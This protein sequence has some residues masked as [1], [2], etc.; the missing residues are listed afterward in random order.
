MDITKATEA[1]L[2]SLKDDIITDIN[3]LKNK[4]NKKKIT[5]ALKALAKTTF[6]A[7][8]VTAAL[9]FPPA[10]V[11]A[12]LGI[13]VALVDGGQSTVQNIRGIKKS[14]VEKK[15]KQEELKGVSEQLILGS[16]R[17]KRFGITQ[18][19]LRCIQILKL[20]K[21]KSESKFCNL[22]K[23]YKNMT[24]EIKNRTVYMLCR[25]DKPEDGT[26]IYVGST[27]QSLP[28]RL[29]EHK[30]KAGNQSRFYGNSKLYKKM[31]EVGVHNWKIVP[32]LTFACNRDTIVAFEEQWVKATGADL[33]TISPVNEDVAKKEYNRRYYKKNKEEKRYYCGVCAVAF[34]HTYI[35]E[36]HLDTLKHS[37]AWLNSVD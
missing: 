2:I 36:K 23:D 26:G 32:L 12:A 14:K 30:Y 17:F 10:I 35:L 20:P 31:R 9:F 13:G 19:R 27:S 7:G 21:I 28:Q 5:F 22:C 34:M 16:V 25:T 1:Q 15:Q 24:D 33:N 29:S 37:Y 18:R 4:S 8:T 11:I 6:V 3:K